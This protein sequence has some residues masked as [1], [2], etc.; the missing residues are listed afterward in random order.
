MIIGFTGTRQGISPIQKQNLESIL[1]NILPEIVIHGGCIGADEEFHRICLEYRLGESLYL[2]YPFIMIYP[3]YLKD[4]QGVCPNPT[5]LAIEQ[6]PLIRNQAIVH[7]S[8]I[9]IAAPKYET[10]ELRSGTWATIRYARKMG[11]PVVILPRD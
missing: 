10:E 11:V 1:D 7:Q 2:P 5:F 3:S 4:Q 9:L 8:D 6:D